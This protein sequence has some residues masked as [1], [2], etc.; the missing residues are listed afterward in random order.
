M[1]KD[2]PSNLI[3]NA[4]MLNISFINKY[5]INSGGEGY[6]VLVNYQSPLSNIFRLD[7][8]LFFFINYRLLRVSFI[9]L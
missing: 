7:P 5:I 6:S 9:E 1:A 3:A 2:K 4:K 8:P